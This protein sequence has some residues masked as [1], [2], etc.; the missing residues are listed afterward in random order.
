MSYILYGDLPKVADKVT[1][2]RLKL[3]GHCLWHPELPA[4]SLVL[5]EPTHRRKSQGRPAKT[6]VDTKGGHWYGKHWQAKD[7]DAGS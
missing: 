4:S 5:W 2:R 3:V 7:P 1:A 6:I